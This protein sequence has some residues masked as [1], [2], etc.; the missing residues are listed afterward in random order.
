MTSTTEIASRVLEEL[1]KANV[2]NDKKK[3]RKAYSKKAR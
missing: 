2:S 1:D 3:K